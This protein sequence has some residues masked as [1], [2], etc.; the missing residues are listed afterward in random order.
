MAASRIEQHYEVCG[1]PIRGVPGA[2]CLLPKGHRGRRA[3][4]SGR[5]EQPGHSCTVFECD[6]CGHIYRGVP[7]ATM[8][9]GPD[10]DDP[11]GHLYYCFLCVGYPYRNGGLHYDAE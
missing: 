6:G 7:H 11:Q 3:R 8:P 9:D 5:G 10:W 4:K 1:A 2:T